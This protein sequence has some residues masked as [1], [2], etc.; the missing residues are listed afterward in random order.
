VHIEL[1]KECASVFAPPDQPEPEGGM[2][3]VMEFETGIVQLHKWLYQDNCPARTLREDFS[4]MENCEPFLMVL[5]DCYDYLCT[6]SG[7]KIEQVARDLAPYEETIRKRATQFL[8][9]PDIATERMQ[10]VHNLA[11]IAQQNLVGF[12]RQLLL[13]HKQC[14]D[15]RGKNAQVELE[16]NSLQ[17]LV[18]AEL[19]RSSILERLEKGFPWSNNYYLYTAGNIYRQL[20]WEENER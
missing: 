10:Q 19:D 18:A 13:H 3:Q 9:L 14:M 4:H 11:I 20:F 12:L 6:S 17:V 15:E 8:T 5:Q 1:A 16:G 7:V 2:Q